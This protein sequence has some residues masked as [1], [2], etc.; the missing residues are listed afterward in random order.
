MTLSI[1]IVNFNTKDL[2][3]DCLDS[4]FKSSEKSKSS[5]DFEVIVVDNGSTDGSVESLK[6]LQT[7]KL[8]KLKIILN[9]EN[10]GLGTANNQAFRQA[11]GEYILFLNPDTLILDNSLELM[12]NWLKNHPRVGALGCQI[13]NKDG[14]VL[15]SGGFFPSLWRVFLW[16]S[17][18]D[19]F[20]L[21]RE[22]FGSYHPPTSFFTKEGNLDWVQGCAFLIRREVFDAVEGFEPKFFMY[23]EEVEFCFRIKKEGWEVWF[24]PKPKIIHLG[25]LKKEAAILGEIKS[26][27]LFYQLHYPHWYLPILKFFLKLAT[28]LRVTLFGI[29]LKDEKLKKIY[30]KAWR[31]I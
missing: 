13:L 7:G 27:L 3:R 23:G 10:L 26:L 20:S 31:T 4:L 24:S 8:T 1:I 30:L 17:A 16:A 12:V 5:F 22:V 25:G 2:L 29:I 14:E 6:K 15:G 18:L 11:Q 19:H 21:I 28:L 9:E